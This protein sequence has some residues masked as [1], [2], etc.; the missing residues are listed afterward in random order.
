MKSFFLSKWI[1]KFTAWPATN[2]VSDCW[3]EYF[4]WYAR[5]PSRVPK[6]DWY[7][8]MKSLCPDR[9]KSNEKAK[10]I[11][12]EIGINIKYKMRGTN[13]RNFYRRYFKT[14]EDRLLFEMKYL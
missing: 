5:L 4:Y 10:L 14:E 7:T 8:F 3:D 11:F 6:N 13:G 1:A 12:N 2:D 9:H